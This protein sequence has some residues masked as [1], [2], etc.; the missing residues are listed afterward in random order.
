MSSPVPAGQ[1]RRSAVAGQPGR[2]S[3]AVHAEWTKLRTLPGTSWLLAAT[4]A[5][6]AAA[7]A[8]AAAATSCLPDVA[9]PADITRLSLAGIDL[10]QAMVALVGVLAVSSEYSTGMIAA[11]LT[12]VPRRPAVL[13][14]K[15]IVVSGLALAAGIIAVAGSLLAARLLLP[16]RGFTAA[17]GYPPLSLADGPVLRAAAGSVLYLALIAL[18]SLGVGTLVRDAAAAI[19]VVLGLLYLFPVIASVLTDPTWRRHLE[20]IAP[21]TAGL[22]IQATTGLSNLPLSPWVGLGVLAAWAAAALLA[23][24]MMLQ[25]RDA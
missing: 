18:L 12:A 3:G 4:I 11:T 19:G 20:Q 24:G 2:L 15:A 14:A 8:A 23:G 9:C 25:L 5:A 7:S 6:T 17:R 10:G 21:M 13:A 16:A 1:A 22:D